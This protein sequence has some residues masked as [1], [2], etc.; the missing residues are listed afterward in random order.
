MN[1]SGLSELVVNQ[2]E[3][4]VGGASITIGDLGEQE[5]RVSGLGLI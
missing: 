1:L 5:R 2:G 4:A 3:Q